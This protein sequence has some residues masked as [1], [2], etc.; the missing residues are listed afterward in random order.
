MK[1][2]AIPRFAL[3]VY[4]FTVVTVCAV[5]VEPNTSAQADQH[6]AETLTVGFQKEFA[7]VISEAKCYLSDH[8]SRK[9]AVVL[10]LDETLLDNRAYFAVHKAYDTQL[11]DG[12][13]DQV[14]APGIPATV[15]LVHWLN[16]KRFKVYF[17]SGRREH[18]RKQ[19]EDNLKKIGVT[20]YQ[21]LYLKPN[22]YGKDS[23]ADFKV[24]SQR[25]IEK[26]GYHVEAIIGDQHS[27]LKNALGKGFKL[28]NPLYTVP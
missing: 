21:G 14:E 25:D 3:A 11:W 23:A 18:Q 19:T 22:D 13:I 2:T 1:I 20:R 8:K 5:A 6:L 15:E 28:P 27:D 26:H 24:D 16:Q 12:W 10:D 17:V 4:I 7:S 9:S